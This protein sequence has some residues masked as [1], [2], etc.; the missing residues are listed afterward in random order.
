MRWICKDDIEE[1]LTQ[2]WRNRASVALEQIND[3]NSQAERK[4]ILNN[5]ASRKIWRD[6]YR[7]LPNRLKKKCWYCE[8]E[9]IRSDM[10]VDHFRPKGKVEDDNQHDGYWWLAYD[11]KNY[12]CACT[13][14]NSRRNFEET[15]GG[16][17]CKFPL[18]DPNTRAYSADDDILQETPEILDPFDPDDWMSLWFDGDGLPVA[19]PHCREAQKKKVE[20]SIDMFHL[21]ET[22][23][24]RKR[25][26]IRID[27][28]LQVK[29]LENGNITEVRE[30]K[31][32]LRKMTRDSEI[33]S[34]AA[35]VYLNQ[36]KYLP[37]VK[38]ILS[39]EQD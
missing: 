21:H 18:V 24:T 4:A 38:Q 14:C 23:I 9:E 3:A 5:A 32:N 6:Y 12:R 15:E 20:N 1:N 19:I 28:M 7:C 25:N 39:L 30:A 37:I 36:Y 2:E 10:P 34:R 31:D 26:R 22:R 35:I 8:A 13:Y 27:I 29:K 11:W 16:K 17:A 33:L